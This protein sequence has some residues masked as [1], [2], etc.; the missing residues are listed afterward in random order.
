VTGFD[1]SPFTHRLYW[2]WVYITL[3]YICLELMN[4]LYGLVAVASFLATPS[5]CPRMFNAL[6]QCYSVRRAWSIVWHQQMRRLCSAPGIWLARDKL[7]LRPGSFK[8]KY[9]QLF[10][11]FAVSGAIHAAAAMLCHKSLQD[12]DAMRVF[13]Y[14]AVLIFVEDH[15][16][17]LG[18][19]CGCEDSKAWRVVGF[20]W[21]GVALGTSLQSWTGRSL[22]NGLWVHGRESDFLGLGPR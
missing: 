14:Q 17:A 3:T 6:T 10:T 15:I 18:R 4:T 19:K 22:A 8:S 21:T 2:T 12:D 1:D 11:G 9:T 16:I 20:V 5:D 7:H 13:M